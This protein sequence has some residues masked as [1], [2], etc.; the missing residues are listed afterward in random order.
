MSEKRIFK[1]I[2]LGIKQI[3]QPYYQGVAA[4]LAFYFMLSIVPILIV[5][6]QLLGF[7]SISLEVLSDII[8]EYFDS[9]IAY[10]LQ[11]FITYSPT[12]TMNVF[13]TIIALWSAS[14]VQFS[15]IRIANYT[16]TEGKS[17]GEGY[18]RNRLKA[19]KTMLIAL[20]SVTFALVI[21]VYG[22]P[23]LRLVLSVVNR[24]LNIVYEVDSLLLFIRWPAALAL[25]FLM[26]SYSYYALPYGKVEY[27]KIL[28]GSIFA[29]ISMLLVT[30]LYS[31]YIGYIANFDIIYGSL[32]TFVALMF[33]FFFLSWALVLGVVFNKV[34]Y[35]TKPQ[36]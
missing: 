31:I 7:F 27:R 21:L 18:I 23:L 11:R 30:Y 29:A 3:R 14:K 17:T 24:N 34:Y 9:E 26:V 25:Y 19:M 28:P 35:D 4:Q 10:I 5:F 12:G 20:F 8:N 2:K 32:A 15:M 16:I 1:M 13:F 36:K 33:W 6:S 22:E